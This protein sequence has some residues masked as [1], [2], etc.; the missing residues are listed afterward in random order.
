VDAPL[1]VLMS[2]DTI[3]LVSQSSSLALNEKHISSSVSL[4]VKLMSPM[5]HYQLLDSSLGLY[6]PDL[7]K[8]IV[9]IVVG[10]G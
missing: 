7:V 10:G 3:F 8:V 2:V 5:Q 1:T 9:F 6:V 4:A